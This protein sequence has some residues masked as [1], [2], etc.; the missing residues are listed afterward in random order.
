[1]LSRTGFASEMERERA[2]QRIYH[3]PESEGRPCD[4]WKSISLWQ[5]RHHVGGSSSA[6]RA[7][8]R[9][10]GDSPDTQTTGV[11]LIDLADDRCGFKR[12]MPTERM[13]SVAGPMSGT[14]LVNPKIRLGNRNKGGVC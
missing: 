1:M 8:G 10:P 14:V 13:R 6:A 7:P 2:K 5:P 12:D 9:E 11:Q 3:A 4:G